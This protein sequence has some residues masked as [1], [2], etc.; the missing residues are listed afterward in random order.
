MSYIGLIGVSNLDP[1]NKSGFDKAEQMFNDGYDP[2]VIKI[3][4]GWEQGID[5]F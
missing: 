1:E 3:Q 2:T 4:S 5:G